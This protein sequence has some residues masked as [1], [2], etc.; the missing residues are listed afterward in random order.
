MVSKIVIGAI[1]ARSAFA[2]VN[3]P[4]KEIATGVNMPVLSIGTGGLGRADGGEITKTWLSVGGRGID[5]AQGYGNEADVKASIENSGVKRSDL[6]ITSK[7]SS[8]TKATEAVSSELKKMGLDYFDLLLVHEPKGDF[9][10]GWEELEGLLKKGTLKAIGVSNFKTNDLKKLLPYTTI[11]PA[12]NQIR[13]NLYCHDDETIAYCK[14]QGITVEA[15]SPL[16]GKHECSAE[17]SIPHDEKVIEIAKAHNVSTYQVGLKWIVQHGWMTTFQSTSAEHQES[18]AD[19]FS[20]TLSDDEMKQL[21]SMQ[22]KPEEAASATMQCTG[23]F[24]SCQ[25]PVLCCPGLECRRIP[26]FDDGQCV[27][28]SVTDSIVV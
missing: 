3:V 21:D 2:N 26:P 18:D 13:T 28:G 22:K 15:W 7:I 8:L 5:S 16:D 17:G 6:F 4:T 19:L 25:V 14:E 11:K 9:K 23:E 20:F 27:R 1:L 12:V 24:L 10:T